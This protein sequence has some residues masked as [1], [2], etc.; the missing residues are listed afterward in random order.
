MKKFNAILR[1]A[2]LFAACVSVFYSTHVNAQVPA[3]LPANGLVAWYPFS[4]NANDESGNGNNGAVNGASLDL[5]RFGNAQSA[6]S[7]DGLND[8]ILVPHNAQFNS[9]PLTINLWMKSNGD[10]DGGILLTKYCCSNWQG[11]DIQVSPTN[12]DTATFTREYLRGGCQG[13]FQW[14]C[15]TE[16][17]QQLTAFDEQWHMYTFRIDSSGATIFWDGVAVATQNWIG[18]AG[19]VSNALDILRFIQPAVV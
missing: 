8:D 15:G 10:A 1:H 18:P 12:A 5:D 9:Y 14:Y 3:Y 4:G 17:Q 6:Y 19:P 16:P 11:W 7:F 2:M 13:L